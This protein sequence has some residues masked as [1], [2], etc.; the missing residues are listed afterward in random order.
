MV[1]ASSTWFVSLI[2]QWS[3]FSNKMVGIGTILTSAFAAAA[4]VAAMTSAVGGG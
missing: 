3:L 2:T 1:L 4:M